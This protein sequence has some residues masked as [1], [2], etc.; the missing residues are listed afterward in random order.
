VRLD[1][2]RDL[3]G[4]ARRVRACAV[5]A[6]LVDEAIVFDER[7][8]SGACRGVQGQYTHVSG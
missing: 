2:R 1:E 4:Q 8:A 6:P 5:A 3:R 7:D